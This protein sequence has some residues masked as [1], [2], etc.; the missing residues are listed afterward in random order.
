MCRPSVVTMVTVCLLWPDTRGV[1]FF[2]VWGN[3]IFDDWCKLGALSL[4]NKPGVYL[5][6]SGAEWDDLGRFA[7]RAVETQNMTRMEATGS[8]VRVAG[9]FA[10]QKE[11]VESEGIPAGDIWYFSCYFFCYFNW[12]C[13]ESQL[14]FFSGVRL[15]V[16]ISSS[17]WLWHHWHECFSDVWLECLVSVVSLKML[18]PSLRIK[19]TRG[20]Q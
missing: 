4:K 17:P 9:C 12:S 18:N 5:E 15:G 14:H 7:E 16:C 20:Y 10:V 3:L 6:R 19:F 1:I 8:R 11:H 2:P 13:C